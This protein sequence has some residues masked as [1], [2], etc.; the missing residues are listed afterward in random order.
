M[1]TLQSSTP[2]EPDATGSA[3]PSQTL[4]LPVNAPTA[5]TMRVRPFIP[6]TLGIDP[7]SP[8]AHA[9]LAVYFFTL[10]AMGMLRPD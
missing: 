10:V 5:P 3:A 8:T 2:S 4:N 6:Q 1:P 7:D 9:N